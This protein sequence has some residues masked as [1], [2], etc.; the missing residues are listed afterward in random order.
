MH[1]DKPE[2]GIGKDDSDTFSD[3]DDFIVPSKSRNY[4]RV[5]KKRFG[6]VLMG[7][8]SSAED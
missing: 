7:D 1:V 3:L 6:M 2:V 4:E 5:L 8:D